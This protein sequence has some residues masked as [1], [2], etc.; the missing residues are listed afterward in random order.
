V[1]RQTDSLQWH[2]RLWQEKTTN[3]VLPLPPLQQIQQLLE[4][5][6]QVQELMMTLPQVQELMMTLPQVQELMMTL[7]DVAVLQKNLRS[8]LSECSFLTDPL[9]QRLQRHV[10]LMSMNVAAMLA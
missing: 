2:L 10:I 3:F 1:L 6:P 7:P 8:R 5:L 4:R 9:L